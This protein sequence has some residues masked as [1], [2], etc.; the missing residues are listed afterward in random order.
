MPN[1]LRIHPED[2]VVVALSDLPAHTPV[3]TA[4][5]LAIA[6]VTTVDAIPFGHKIA[7][8]PIGAGQTVVKYGASIGVASQAITSGQHVH[9]HNL[10][11]VRGKV[12]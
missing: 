11:T 5:P 8:A 6:T 4:P 7:I 12:R 2:N 10:R 1:A 9:T 3:E